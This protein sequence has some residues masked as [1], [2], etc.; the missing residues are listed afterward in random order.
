M[1]VKDIMSCDPISVHPS[2]ALPEA[3]HLMA[4]NKIRRLP[5]VV[6]HKL[7]GIITDRDLKAAGPS[8]KS[9]L[10]FWDMAYFLSRMTVQDI[11]SKNVVSVGPEAPLE[12]AILLMYREKI[13]GLPVVDDNN[14][15]LGIITETDALRFL[16]SLLGG[17]TGQLQI[18]VADDA[19]SRSALGL[20]LAIPG[21]HS[22]L[23]QHEP[24]AVRV[25]FDLSGAPDEVSSILSRLA[26]LQLEVI[27]CR[28]PQGQEPLEGSNVTQMATLTR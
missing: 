9:T 12:T 6:H 1:R 2:L 10:N 13:G 3:V 15:L 5:V 11:M 14:K 26:E 4:E 25:V 8:T 27:E 7:C 28:A 16:A 24:P 20:V 18:T 23:A 22:M 19:E 21:F 17:N